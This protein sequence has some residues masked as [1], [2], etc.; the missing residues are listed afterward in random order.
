MQMRVDGD[1]GPDWLA[2]SSTELAAVAAAEARNKIRDP[3]LGQA[4]ELVPLLERLVRTVHDIEA[5]CDR[6]D[7]LRDTAPVE[8]A[9]QC[10]VARVVHGLQWDDTWSPWRSTT[11]AGVLA[12]PWPEERPVCRWVYDFTRAHRRLPERSEMLDYLRRGY[13]RVRDGSVSR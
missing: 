2:T 7:R 12:Q 11:F 6:F 9:P 8:D 13:V 10:H 4:R 3:Y 1:D 5:V